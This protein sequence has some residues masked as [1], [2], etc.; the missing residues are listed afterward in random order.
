MK[1]IVKAL[2]GVFEELTSRGEV[3]ISRKRI[4]G[5]PAQ[6]YDELVTYAQ[7]N[8]SAGNAALLD[9]D[10][11][12]SEEN[13]FEKPVSGQDAIE[14]D[15]FVTLRQLQSQAVSKVR[16]ELTSDLII[17]WQN[18]QAVPGKTF[19]QALGDNFSWSAFYELGGREVSYQPAVAITRSSGVIMQ[20]EILDVNPGYII[21][22]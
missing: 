14:Q 13:H 3:I 19:A 6:E 12:F 1:N 18:N 9:E 15:D 5:V 4:R 2:K 11:I 22:I 16:V 10:N 17:D 7:L 21:F 8:E 20:V